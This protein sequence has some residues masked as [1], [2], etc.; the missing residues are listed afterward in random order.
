M[1]S[2]TTLDQC[3]RTIP[4][5]RRAS[6]DRKV[7]DRKILTKVARTIPNWRVAA[8]FFPGV[9]KPDVEAILHDNMLSLEQE[10]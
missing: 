9:G 8:S 6:L 7:E 10:K 2:L 1:A 3:L 5:A 4:P